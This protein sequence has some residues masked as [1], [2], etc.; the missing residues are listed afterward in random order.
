M[1]SLKNWLKQSIFE[2]QGIV[3]EEEEEE[4]KGFWEFCPKTR[5]K[6]LD[7]LSYLLVFLFLKIYDLKFKIYEYFRDW[8]FVVLRVGLISSEDK[9]NSGSR[10]EPCSR[11]SFLVLAKKSNLLK[12][13]FWHLFTKKHQKKPSKFSWRCFTK[14]FGAV[15][16]DNRKAFYFL[17]LDG[18]YVPG[19]F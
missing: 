3:Q 6:H 9:R 2:R 15:K 7:F 11:I 16:I 12:A 19:G 4:V 14:M 10:A 5:Q 13:D 8:L 17:S 1:Y 18:L